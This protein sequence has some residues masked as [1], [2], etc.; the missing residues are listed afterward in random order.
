MSGKHGSMILVKETIKD[1]VELE[2]LKS[3]FQEEIIGIEIK[4]ND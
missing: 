1:V 3:Q 2:F 4:G